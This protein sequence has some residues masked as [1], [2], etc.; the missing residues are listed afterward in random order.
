[1]RTIQLYKYLL[2]G[3]NTIITPSPL[4]NY[5]YTSTLWRLVADDGFQLTDG[6]SIRTCV[7]T[8]T[9]ENWSEILIPNPNLSEEESNYITSA[10]ILFGEED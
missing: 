1:M 4:E 5:S 6:T 7:D 3:N 9:P 10:K 8:E 2:E